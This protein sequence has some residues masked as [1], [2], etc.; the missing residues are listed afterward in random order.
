MSVEDKYND[1]EIDEDDVDDE[2]EIE[3]DD[4]YNNIY[5]DVRNEVEG[6]VYEFIYNRYVLPM[7]IGEF[8]AVWY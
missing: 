6:I 2:D 4:E 1:V 8:D 5:E 3:D 7:A